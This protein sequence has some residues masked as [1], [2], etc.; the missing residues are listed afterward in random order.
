ML[1]NGFSERSSDTYVGKL[2]KIQGKCG[3]CQVLIEGNL[4]SCR[5]ELDV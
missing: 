2:C 5:F 1:C 4:I 3:A